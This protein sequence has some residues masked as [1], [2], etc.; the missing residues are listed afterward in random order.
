MRRS[1]L[2]ATCAAAFLTTAA[3]A[4]PAASF[5]PPEQ[6]AITD[7]FKGTVRIVRKD[8]APV[9]VS[10]VIRT[11]IISNRQRLEIPAGGAMLVQ[12]RGGDL[13]TI[14]RGERKERSV[15]EFWTVPSR[16]PMGIETGRD[17]VLLH[18]VEIVLP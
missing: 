3:H 18:A 2:L 15:E 12:H 5:D 14:I 7:L 9:D 17:S 11:M 4:Q 16:M 8:G 6:P 13:V 1:M 10:V